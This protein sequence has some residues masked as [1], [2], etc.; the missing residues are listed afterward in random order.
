MCFEAGTIRTDDDD[1]AVTEAGQAFDSIFQPLTKAGS[2]VPLQ[3]D[4]VRT[5]PGSRRLRRGEDV[6]V[7]LI[8]GKSGEFAGIEQLL[9]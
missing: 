1:P 5:A 3:M 4:S 7:C 2:G 9:K 8:R 6:N